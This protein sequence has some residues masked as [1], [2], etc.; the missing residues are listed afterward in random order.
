MS[1][2]TITIVAVITLTVYV[3]AKIVTEISKASV[4]NAQR[5]SI[6]IHN[7]KEKAVK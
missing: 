2:D 7:E 3:C 1:S 5:E 6:E 4:N